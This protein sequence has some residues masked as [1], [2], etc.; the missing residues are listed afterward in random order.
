MKQARPYATRAVEIDDQSAEAHTAL[1]FVNEG[2]WNWTEAEKEYRRAIELNPSYGTAQTRYARFQVRIP[3]RTAEGAERLKRAL[4]LEPASLV[5][6]DNLSQ[7]YLAQGE[8]DLAIAQAKRTVELDPRYAFG[9]L[10]LSY[11]YLKKGQSSE[12][13]QSAQKVVEVSNRSSRSLVC[14]GFVTAMS[15][16]RAEAITLLG[17]LE[18][19]YR[20]GQAD[21]TEVAAIYA[22][23]GE[24]D[25]AYRWLDTA[26]NDRSSLLADIRAEFPFALLRDDA[27]YKDL[28][29]RM[30]M[31]E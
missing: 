24:K 28:L 2:T 18:N 20:N 22:G 26:F 31:P 30:G 25:Q 4:D 8:V 13:L 11:A 9:W 21:A 15:G 17:E 16:K 1:A 19:H 5:A 27:R 14:L 29:R 23:L 7:T 6:S 12:A 10:D 3:A